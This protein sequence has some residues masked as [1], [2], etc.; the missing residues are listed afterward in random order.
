MYD[1]NKHSV[2]QRSRGSHWTMKAAMNALI[3]DIYNHYVRYHKEI[4]YAFF[5]HENAPFYC[6]EGDLDK[7]FCKR[8]IG[9]SLRHNWQRAHKKM[10]DKYINSKDNDY[11]YIAYVKDDRKKDSEVKRVNLTSNWAAA[12][13]KYNQLVKGSSKEYTVSVMSHTQQQNWWYPMTQKTGNMK[14]MDTYEMLA[15]FCQKKLEV[16]KDS[17]VDEKSAKLKTKET[18]DSELKE[19]DEKLK[20]IFKGSGDTLYKQYTF[21]TIFYHK[22]SHALSLPFNKNMWSMKN[23]LIEMTRLVYQRVFRAEQDYAWMFTVK[24]TVP[25][26][27]SEEDMT[28][29]EC[30]R[31]LGWAIYHKYILSGKKMVDTY[32]S[33][34]KAVYMAILQEKDGGKVVAKNLTANEG[35]SRKVFLGMFQ[36][37][38]PKY[39]AGVLTHRGKHFWSNPISAH[40]D[41]TKN[42]DVYETIVTYA[43][44]KLKIY[45]KDGV[46]EKGAKLITKKEI[47]EKQKVKYDALRKLFKGTSDRLHRTYTFMLLYKDPVHK[48]MG[49]AANHRG[50]TFKHAFD[51]VS[52]WIYTYYIKKNIDYSYLW[53]SYETGRPLFCSNKDMK[54]S[55]CKQLLAF[56]MST[57]NFA[58]ADQ[59]LFGSSTIFPEDTKKYTYIALI[60]DTT[61]PDA[62]YEE[63]P[64]NSTNYGSIIAKYKELA[65]WT[66]KDSNIVAVLTHSSIRGFTN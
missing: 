25:I 15:D 23:A 55:E 20:G 58:K 62:K 38:K 63:I 64:L 53:I 37:E 2:T 42:L 31:M 41:A 54:S 21:S 7:V 35:N 43:Q 61:K 17:G 5:V 34:S 66:K 40:K 11:Q 33:A 49:N 48:R 45:T 22:R 9:Y 28:K 27:C 24:Q 8:M 32:M 14:Y 52:N 65:D 10:I 30:Q 3:T 18:W 56:G 13:A 29:V 57:Y 39:S 50:S 51:Q 47:L 44:K 26:F 1:K 59:K 19:A 36:G 12:V 46:D 16:W 4:A 6:S 60:K